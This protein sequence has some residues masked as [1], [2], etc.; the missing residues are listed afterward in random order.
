M[1]IL[2]LWLV[3]N[4]IIKPLD[5]GGTETHSMRAYMTFIV[6]PRSNVIMYKDS[7][8]ACV[9]NLRVLGAWYHVG[10]PISLIHIGHRIPL[11]LIAV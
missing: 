5:S 2:L 9:F 11:S 6:V 7:L 1:V 8:I 3:T 10:Y 4:I